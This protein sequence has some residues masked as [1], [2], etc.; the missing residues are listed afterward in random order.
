VAVDLTD[1]SL[2]IP[3]HNEQDSLPTLIRDALQCYK[4]WKIDGEIVIVDDGS[5]DRTLAVAEELC[6]KETSIRVLRLDERRGKTR[7]LQEGLRLSSGKVI[8]IVDADLQYDLTELPSL[9]TPILSGH[10]DLVNGWRVE[11]RDSMSKKF[12][13]RVFNR[14]NQWIFG[15]TTRDANSGFKAMRRELLEVITPF[16]QK[17]FHRYLVSISGY[18]GYRILEIPI[19]HHSRKVGR[20]KY[21]NPI[22]LVTG[23]SDMLR[24]RWLLRSLGHAVTKPTG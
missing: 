13:S 10:F 3:A 11:R 22:R 1:I 4:R 2:I 14:M 6:K 9:S 21:S 17:D 16:L 8:A 15:V 24:V 5:T 12:S 7:A 19:S 20:S 18:M 23:F